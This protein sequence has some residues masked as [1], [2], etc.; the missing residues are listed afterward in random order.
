MHPS[1]SCFGMT[2]TSLGLTHPILGHLLDFCL[3][4][5]LA[6]HQF[7]PCSIPATTCSSR[8]SSSCSEWCESGLKDTQTPALHFTTGL[9][10]SVGV[11]SGQ[12]YEWMNEW[13]SHLYL[14]GWGDMCVCACD[15]RHPQ[16]CHP[17]PLGQVRTQWTRLLG[18]GAWAVFLSVL[19][20]QSWITI[21]CIQHF[22]PSFWWLDLVLCACE[23]REHLIN[24]TISLAFPF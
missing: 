10:L 11:F 14:C 13:M 6:I 21:M 22:F 16:G 17:A 4:M 15:G 23:A 19:P 12:S 18:S 2:T 9:S 24:W 8:E 20:P 1:W 3:E 7:W 5:F